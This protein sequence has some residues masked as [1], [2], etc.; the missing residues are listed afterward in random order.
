MKILFVVD[1]LLNTN[2]ATVEIAKSLAKEWQSQGHSVLYMCNTPDGHGRP[3]HLTL[4]EF[5]GNPTYQYDLISEK[6]VNEF[7]HKLEGK[8]TLAK[9]VALLTHPGLWDV[10]YDSYFAEFKH[11]ATHIAYHIETIAHQENVDLIYSI[12]EPH[13]CAYAVALAQ[14]S[15]QCHKRAYLVDPYAFN[16][17]HKYEKSRVVER[18]ILEGVERLFTTKQVMNDYRHDDF[19]RPYLDKVTAVEFPTLVKP[20]TKTEP[21]KT[22]W[23]NDTKL[24]CVY[25]GNIYEGI[26][27]Q[28]PIEELFIE[29]PVP[30]VT[31]HTFG[32][33]FNLPLENEAVI[34]HEPVP[35][36]EVTDILE[37]ADILINLGNTVSNM[38]PSKLFQL[39][40][41]GK[42]IVNLCHTAS[43]PTLEYT[44]LYPLSCDLILTDDINENRRKL[45]DFC[46]SN[47]GSRISYEKV[48]E[49][50]GECTPA[51]VAEELL[52]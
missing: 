25:A 11:Y 28:W 19:F 5:E 12:S 42:P 4:I 8:G 23:D 31:L 52:L 24:H 1:K 13:Y 50:F 22:Y 30:N 10:L 37:A 3:D 15:P 40:A 49:I 35:T 7:M 48:E 29:E 36:E 46:I 6:F 39:M 34:V 21:A 14:V 33:G 44:K 2:D 47:L 20:E 9:D 27:P 45:Y 18:Y 32:K 17:T 26:R 41:T 51:K 16:H 43:D 38:V